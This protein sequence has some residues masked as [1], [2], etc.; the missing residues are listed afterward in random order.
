MNTPEEYVAWL[1]NKGTQ[2]TTKLAHSLDETLV[3]ADTKQGCVEV[4]YRVSPDYCNYAG[5][6]HGGIIATMAD[7]VGGIAAGVLI[8]PVPMT[9]I[10]FKISYFSKMLPGRALGRGRVVHRT[11]KIAFAEVEMLDEN[12]KSCAK[13]T[14]TYLYRLPEDGQK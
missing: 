5:S 12:G 13:A 11:G 3:A 2:K 8:G 14:A 1:R 4:E 6:V 9:T 10:E 7:Q